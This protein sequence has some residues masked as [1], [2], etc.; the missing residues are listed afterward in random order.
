MLGLPLL[1]FLLSHWPLGDRASFFFLSRLGGAQ[2]RVGRVFESFFVAHFQN[3]VPD[4]AEN[5]A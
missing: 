1:C 5:T 3:G 4:H 2:S